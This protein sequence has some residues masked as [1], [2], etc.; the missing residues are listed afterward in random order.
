M[1]ITNG[2]KNPLGGTE[3]IVFDAHLD[4]V[5]SIHQQTHALLLAKHRAAVQRRWWA[6]RLPTSVPFLSGHSQFNSVKLQTLCLWIGYTQSDLNKDF[7]VA[8]T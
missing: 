8:F 1:D 2:G 5:N 7:Q 6:Q 3:F 4:R